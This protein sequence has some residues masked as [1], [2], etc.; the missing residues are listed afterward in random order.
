MSGQVEQNGSEDRLVVSILQ[1]LSVAALDLFDPHRP[2]GIFLERVAERM[3]CPV[4]LVLAA[5]RHGPM[6]LLDAAGLSASSRKLAL[7][8]PAPATNRAA[9]DDD[10]GQLPYPELA[11]AGMVIW[12]FALAGQDGIGA[13]SGADTLVLCFDHAPSAAP[14]R[15]MMRR[16]ARIFR[17]A[18]VHRQLALRRIE[19]EGRAAFLAEASRLLAG[20][21]DYQATLACVAGLPV[22]ALGDCCLLDIIDKEGVLRRAAV[23]HAD[24]AQLAEARRLEGQPAQ[25]SGPPGVLAALAAGELVSAALPPKSPL[26]ALGLRHTLSVPLATRGAQIGVLTIASRHQDHDPS[27]DDRW[28]AGEFGQRA[29]LAI[30]NARLYDSAQH[31]IRAREELV[32]VVSHDLKNPLNIITLNTS[33]LRGLDLRPED[34]SISR[35]LE[36]M[37]KS[38]NRMGH[39]IRDLL[40]LAKLDGGHIALARQPHPVAGLI[41]EAINLLREEAAKKSLHVDQRIPDDIGPLFCDRERI[42]QVIENLVSNAIKFTPAGGEIVIR[43][44]PV[45]SD[46]VLSVRDSGPGIPEAERTRI[47]DRFW[48]AQ[49]SAPGGT[50]LGLS[51]AKGLVEVHGG[52]IW[53]ES[54]PGA[55]STFLVALPAPA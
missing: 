18:L 31:A 3:G 50:G 51:I 54:Q 27:D 9:K 32:A 2:M 14:Y 20:S 24:P 19:S 41:S 22:P 15:G 7:V 43:A 12:Q 17:T 36:L 45:G 48:Q 35:A 5:P 23:A 40:D 37:E 29:A 42:I 21:L 1:E 4:V 6:R 52:R 53:A 16:L 34:P 13:D 10:L 38:A 25:I 30:D 39:L 8:T 49:Q 11:R 28:L 55:G 46:V 44:E 26:A 33:V 47:F